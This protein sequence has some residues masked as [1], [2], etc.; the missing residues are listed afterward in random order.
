VSIIEA[1]FLGQPAKFNLGFLQ[2]KFDQTSIQ[3]QAAVRLKERRGVRLILQDLYRLGA[4]GNVF[5]VG[6]RSSDVRHRWIFRGESSLLLDKPME[7]HPALIRRL[8]GSTQGLQ[9]RLQR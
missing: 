8:R 7:L 2:G 9:G 3:N 5:R 6:A 1:F 4:V